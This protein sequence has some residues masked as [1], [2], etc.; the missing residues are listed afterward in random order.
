MPK[1]LPYRKVKLFP[2]E[3]K[4]VDPEGRTVEGFVNVPTTDRANEIVNPEAFL[5]AWEGDWP[6]AVMKPREDTRGFVFGPPAPYKLNPIYTYNHDFWAPIGTVLEVALQD[7]KPWYKAQVGAANL[8]SVDPDQLL[9][10]IAE[11]TI[12]TSS[13]GYNELQV[14]EPTGPDQPRIIED[15]E[16]LDT[17]A[18]SVPCN[19][20]AT[21]EMSKLL[22][23]PAYA[24]AATPFANLPTADEE[25]TWSWNAR[26]GTEILGDDEDWAKY[27]RA[28]F[29]FDPEASETRAGYKLPFALMFDGTMKAVWRGCAAAMGAL[30]GGRGGV[31]IPDGDRQGVYNHIA[32]Y[33]KKF[34]KETP[35]F[36][37]APL[38]EALAKGE[39]P[40]FGDVTW[41]AEENVVVAEVG[42]D[43]DLRGIQTRVDG[44]ARVLGFLA[45][46]G[47]ILSAPNREAVEQTI[48]A[49]RAVLEA[50]D[51]TD[52]GKAAGEVP[53]EEGLEA[54]LALLEPGVAASLKEAIRQS[55]EERGVRHA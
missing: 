41:K 28:H 43:D 7:G 11:G 37:G 38:A 39:R 35:E 16:Q 22:G 26:A 49:L 51:A 20:Y 8:G 23:L 21:V 17:A 14:I 55:K 52:G 29:W 18:V 44:S 15:F 3:V 25:E 32:R 27:K 12:R 54:A 40:E 46:Q 50:A 30:M 45:K 42:L 10:A 9:Q 5:R 31:D 53:P 19:A 33:Y 47:R 6:D 2:F 4:N 34:E 1:P 24:K 13:F 36:R 48:A